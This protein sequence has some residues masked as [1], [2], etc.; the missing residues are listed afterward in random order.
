MP[1]TEV[2]DLWHDERIDA[3]QKYH[4][5]GM[6]DLISSMNLCHAL[7]ALAD[8]GLLDRLRGDEPRKAGDL[9]DGMDER[10]GTGL[11]R[12][13]HVCGVLDEWHSTY[14]LSLRG[15]LLT[16][17]V[18]LA[19]LGFYLEAY[20]PVTR[21]ITG[22]LTGTLKYGVDVTRADGSLSKH[23]GTVTTTSYTAVVRTAMRGTSAT[24]LLDLGCGSGALLVGMC[25]EQPELTGAGID[26][27]PAAI[28]AAR[29]RAAASGLADR[30]DFVVADAFQPDTWP[31]ACRSADVICGVGVLHE[32]F[33]DGEQAVVDIL[34][35]YA[36]VLTGEKILLLGEPELRYDN[37][38]NDSDFF[39]VH[40]LTAQGIPRDRAGWLDVF[41]KTS[42]TCRR[43]YTNAV[44]GPRTCFYEL[45]PRQG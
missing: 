12:Y 15:R 38:E 10:V 39:L 31:R 17:P 23:T 22:L 45:T 42:L 16:E 11:L 44:A 8:S 35:R 29:Q 30:V 26:I 24:R 4:L 20:A 7:L 18:A 37:R 40:V 36:D 2:V 19:R 6:P 32:Q 34:N 25:A 9:L 5:S 41:G 3:W 33:R 14:R 28:D 27:A 13:L 21:N 43:I 1:E